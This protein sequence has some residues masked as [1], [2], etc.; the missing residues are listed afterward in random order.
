MFV[1]DTLIDCYCV[2]SESI[3]IVRDQRIGRSQV[4]FSVVALKGVSKK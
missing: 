1:N 2:S 3:M 4:V